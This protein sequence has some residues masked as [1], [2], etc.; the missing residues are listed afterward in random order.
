MEKI[1]YFKF[2]VAVVNDKIIGLSFY[3]IEYSTWKGKYLFLEDF[4]V[5]EKY[6]NQG[7]GS[8]LFEETIRICK[9]ESMNGM[10]ASS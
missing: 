2:I 6:R 4:I 1:P 7:V 5:T 10:F 8:K 3:F 9:S